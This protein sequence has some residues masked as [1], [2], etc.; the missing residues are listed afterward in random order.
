MNVDGE[1]KFNREAAGSDWKSSEY[2]QLALCE[3]AGNR[4]INRH[5]PFKVCDWLLLF[6]HCRRAVTPRTAVL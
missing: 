6:D 5:I 4:L 1:G 3:A 2:A